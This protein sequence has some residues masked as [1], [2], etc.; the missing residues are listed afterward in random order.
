MFI[1]IK[2][3]DNKKSLKSLEIKKKAKR[4]II[5]YT[6]YTKILLNSSRVLVKKL[7]KNVSLLHTFSA[8]SYAWTRKILKTLSVIMLFNFIGLFMNSIARMAVPR[9]NLNIADRTI[10]IYS[11]GCLTAFVM[12]LNAPILFTFK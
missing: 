6:S 7:G 9:L 11:L 8:S 12:S 5:F 4:K 2:S 3:Y 1:I 10:V